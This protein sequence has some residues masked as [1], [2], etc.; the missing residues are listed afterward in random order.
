MKRRDILETVA[1]SYED[2]MRYSKSCIVTNDW[3]TTN[4]HTLIV[5]LKS[6]RHD[7]NRENRYVFR[8]TLAFQHIPCVFKS[9]A[10]ILSSSYRVPYHVVMRIRERMIIMLQRGDST[11]P[12]VEK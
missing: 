6:A 2:Q 3:K 9:S 4:V 1:L 7:A 10:H 8:L 12:W 11:R 5:P